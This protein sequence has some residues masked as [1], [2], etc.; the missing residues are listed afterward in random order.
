MYAS[1]TRFLARPAAVTLSTLAFSSF[2]TFF[3]VR[4]RAPSHE[5]AQWLHYSLSYGH[6]RVLLEV[7]RRSSCSFFYC[8]WRKTYFT[9][10]LCRPSACQELLLSFVDFLLLFPDIC[11]CTKSTCRAQT[12]AFP[13]LRFEVCAISWTS[14]NRTLVVHIVVSKIGIK[15]LYDNLGS[16]MDEEVWGT[17]GFYLTVCK[18]DSRLRSWC[19]QYH[20]MLRLKLVCVKMCAQHRPYLSWI[21]TV[22]CYSFVQKARFLVLIRLPS[23]LIQPTILDPIIVWRFV[24]LMI[25][26]MNTP[27]LIRP[28]TSIIHESAYY[29]WSFDCGINLAAK[30]LTSWRPLFICHHRL[31]R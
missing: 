18:P 7:C 25:S 15:I 8:P 3:A 13:T 27:R 30:L 19:L 24:S 14:V 5:V 9:R 10:K 31:H 26:D 28:S 29:L 4:G 20:S 17:E 23:V 21:L 16:A 12:E 11:Q 6:L 2:P 22:Y 1:R